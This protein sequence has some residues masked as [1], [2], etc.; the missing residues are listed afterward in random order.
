MSTHC[1]LRLGKC[2]SS[3]KKSQMSFF[4]FFFFFFFFF[5]ILGP[6][7]QHMEIPRLVVQSEL[8]LL[9]YATVTAMPD[10]SH[11]GELHHSPQQHRILNPLSKVR[12]Q[13]HIFMDASWVLNLL[14]HDRNS[15]F[16]LSD[17]TTDMSLYNSIYLTFESHYILLLE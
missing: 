13:T 8:Q 7:L 1:P 5:G 4:S 11:S 17:L 3:L 2:Y 14:S 12:D 15:I 10:P 6:H 9:A 16:F